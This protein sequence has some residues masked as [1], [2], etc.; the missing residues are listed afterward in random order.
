MLTQIFLHWFCL[1]VLRTPPKRRDCLLSTQ[2]K[3][4]SRYHLCQHPL[5]FIELFRE[6]ITWSLQLPCWPYVTAFSKNGLFLDYLV[7]GNRL[8]EFT[9]VIRSMKR[10]GKKW[11]GRLHIKTTQIPPF[12]CC[13]P[14]L[15]LFIYPTILCKFFRLAKKIRKSVDHRCIFICIYFFLNFWKMNTAVHLND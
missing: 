9:W 13:I 2:R 10:E 6:P 12:F 3:L 11:W 7:A 4:D 14:I 8:L 15:P 1:P 5:V